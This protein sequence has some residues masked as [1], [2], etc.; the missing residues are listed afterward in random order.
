VLARLLG[1]F[2]YAVSTRAAADLSAAELETCAALVRNGLAVRGDT[3]AKL[4]RA[5]ELA[6]ATCLGNI[7]G[8]G[9]IKLV[10]PDYALKIAKRSGFDFPSETPE[11]GYVSV[12][13]NHKDNGLS[14]RIT[15]QL[16]KDKKTPF[17]ATTDDKYMK[18]TLIKAGFTCQG[19]E[20]EGDRGQL[21]LWLRA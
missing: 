19:G 17:F 6:V 8:V 16:L 7:V 3:K 12:D 20:W 2:R 9:A 11:L 10:R 5:A 13:G 4:Q 1:E 21:S 18:S 15:A 14:G